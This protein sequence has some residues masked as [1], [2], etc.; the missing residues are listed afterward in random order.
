ME[1][2]ICYIAYIH[3]HIH[4]LNEVNASISTIQLKK[5]KINKKKNVIKIHTV[6]FWIKSISSVWISTILTFVFN[7]HRFSFELYNYIYILCYKSMSI[8]NYDVCIISHM[9]SLV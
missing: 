1:K 9:C 5:E 7:I 8:W 2:E 3:T 4:T 6:S